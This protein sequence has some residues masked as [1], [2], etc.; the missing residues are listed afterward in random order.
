MRTTVTSGAEVAAAVE[1]LRRERGVGV[2]EVINDLL[3]RGLRVTE[4]SEP[5]RRP[6]PSAARRGPRQLVTDLRVTAGLA[7]DAHLAALALEHGMGIWSTD[8]DFTRCPGLR[9]ADPLT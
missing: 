3:R 7:S 4:P 2:S 9:W 1:R 5:F 6:C 8:R